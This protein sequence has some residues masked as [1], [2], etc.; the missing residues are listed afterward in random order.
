MKLYLSSYRMGDRFE[1]LVAATPKGARVSVVSNAVDYIPIEQRRAYIKRIF[2]PIATFARHGFDASDLDL[3]AYFGRARAL[4]HALKETRIIFAV[5][6]NSFLLRRAMRQSGLDELLP[7]RLAAGDPIYG[8]WS[9]GA[10]VAGSDMRAIELM[11]D[12]NL[13]AD[14]YDPAVIWEGLGLL[15]Y[16]VIPHYRSG[17][18][19][20]DAAETAVA[21]RLELGLP[22]RT[23]RDGEV[24][25][26]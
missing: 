23:L 12:P 3:R 10:C 18:P 26:V 5:G 4:E 6:G 21:M 22:L 8:G 7:R 9:A 15:D 19:E 25:I 11:D 17:P 13:I 20:S 14:L 16:C 2:D 24:V 1:E